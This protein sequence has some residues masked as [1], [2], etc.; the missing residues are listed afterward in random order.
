MFELG[1]YKAVIERGRCAA[2]GERLLPLFLFRDGPIW[3][4]WDFS[5]KG[6]FATFAS[7]AGLAFGLDLVV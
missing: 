1:A 5:W 2:G 7:A 6:A 3:V 4:S